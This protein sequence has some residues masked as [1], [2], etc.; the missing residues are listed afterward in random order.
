MAL[1]SLVQREE[2]EYPTIVSPVKSKAP[3]INSIIKKMTQDIDD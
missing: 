1:P 2:A 3:L